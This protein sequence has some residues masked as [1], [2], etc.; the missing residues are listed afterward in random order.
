MPSK[1]RPQL[2][3]WIGDLGKGCNYLSAADERL[4]YANDNY[5]AFIRKTL[6]NQLF[7]FFLSGILSV[8]CV[9]LAILCFFLCDILIKKV[10]IDLGVLAFT[11]LIFI[12][13]F[14]ALYAI[15]IP[16]FYQNLFAKRGEPIIFNRKTQ[17]VYINESYFFNFKFWRNPLMFLLPAKRRIK[18]YNW[19]DL[20]GIVVHNYSRNALTTTIMMVCKPGTHQTIDHIMLDPARSGIGS[21]LVWGWVNNFMVYFHLA[22][23]NDGRYL[24][25]Q[26]DKFNRNYIK[27]QGWPQW[28]QDA[29]NARSLDELAQIKQK[30]GIKE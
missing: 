28:M 8:S 16:E 24:T 11:I 9:I 5:C 15:L 19:A 22:N 25:T 4:I 17:K 21:N 23:L 26:E 7:Y 12:A 6:G 1:Y 27:G 13:L 29:F 18:E 10:E 14:I 30:Y 2:F 20:H 3:G